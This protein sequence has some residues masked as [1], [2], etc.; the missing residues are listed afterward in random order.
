MKDWRKYVQ[1]MIEVI[2]HLESFKTDAVPE[3]ILQLAIE[4]GFE[5]LGEASR[6]MPEEIRLKYPMIPWEKMV[7]TRNFIA[8][9]YERILIHI[10]RDTI[11]KHLPSLKADLLALLANES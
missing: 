2:D 3:K 10:L 6:R 1:D 4:R 9:D 11:D 7:S 5:I 8:H